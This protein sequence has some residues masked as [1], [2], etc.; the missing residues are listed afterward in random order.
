ME[1]QITINQGKNVGGDFEGLRLIV[2]PAVASLKGSIYGT[3]F[4]GFVK[5]GYYSRLN[6]D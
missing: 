4:G 1:R 5:I 6:L 2:E 3:I